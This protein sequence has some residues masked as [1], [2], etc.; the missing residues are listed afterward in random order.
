MGGGV[1]PQLTKHSP[2]AQREALDHWGACGKSSSMVPA[3]AL[4]AR[5]SS[6]LQV[7]QI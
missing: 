3:E 6:R 1:G 5:V 7:A 4:E 2:I